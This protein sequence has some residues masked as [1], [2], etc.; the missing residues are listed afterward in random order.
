MR[1][2]GAEPAGAVIP[3]VPAVGIADRLDGH[4]VAELGG[5]QD[6]ADHLDAGLLLV[7]RREVVDDGVGLGPR[8]QGPAQGD[9]LRGG[10]TRE[11]G[12]SRERG[13]SQCIQFHI[14]SPGESNRLTPLRAGASDGTADC[15]TCRGGCLPRTSRATASSRPKG[16]F[17]IYQTAASIAFG[18]GR[19]AREARGAGHAPDPGLSGQRESRL[20]GLTA[21]SSEP[22]CKDEV[23]EAGR[24]ELQPSGKTVRYWDKRSQRPLGAPACPQ[25]L[26]R[27]LAARCHGSEAASGSEA[28]PLLPLRPVRGDFPP[29]AVG[30][31]GPRR[32]RHGEHRKRR[33]PER[34]KL[35]R[36]ADGNC[37]A[38]SGAE[39][40]H[41]F[42]AAVAPPHFAAAC[43]DV[44]DLIDRAMTTR[45]GH[46]AR[47]KLEVR[48]ASGR[49]GKQLA[50][51]RS[52]RRG[53]IGFSGKLPCPESRRSSLALHAGYSQVPASCP[54]P[55]LIEL[56]RGCAP[57]DGEIAAVR[58]ERARP[59]ERRA[60][61]EWNVDRIGATR[62]SGTSGSP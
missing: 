25:S 54:S 35:E 3:H 19:A 58:R 60:A 59:H 30:F 13:Q 10:L 37:Q 33:I 22:R 43:E 62:G 57:R 7:L 61:G 23:G 9:V 14:S 56:L 2:E 32:H 11:R 46:R 53:H 44:P 55:P 6:L 5:G 45:P 38:N 36:R 21:G 49:E 28:W 24:A 27:V 34:A 51:V 8:M 41:L 16:S 52:V 26:T 39:R 1:R 42:T 29:F 17:R 48:R 15:G 31:G 40:H 12:R 20:R 4:L 50:H 47:R 18:Q